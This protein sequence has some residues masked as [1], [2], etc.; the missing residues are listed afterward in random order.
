[1][2]IGL[3]NVER[4]RYCCTLT[5]VRT[6]VDILCAQLNGRK[7]QRHS[8]YSTVQNNHYESTDDNNHH[9]NMLHCKNWICDPYDYY[10]ASG[11]VRSRLL[12]SIL[13]RQATVVVVIVV[14]NTQ[15]W[16]ES[17]CTLPKG[18]VQHRT[19]GWLL[20]VRMRYRLSLFLFLSQ[21]ECDSEHWHPLHTSKRAS[22]H[23]GTRLLA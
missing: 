13:K 1:M 3:S 19:R 10:D 7:G 16:N 9:N 8:M 20:L 23:S 2:H 17:W 21:L 6:K 22:E 18:Q 15:E 4:V 5:S 14:V 11:S 12:F